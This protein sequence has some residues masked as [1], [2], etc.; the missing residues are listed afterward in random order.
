LVFHQH[1][2]I[3]THDPIT[4]PLFDLNSGNSGNNGNIQQIQVLTKP[5]AGNTVATAATPLT[6]TASGTS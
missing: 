1:T 4:F 6:A 3:T 5:H 2:V